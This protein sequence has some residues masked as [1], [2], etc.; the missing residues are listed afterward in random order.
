MI[1]WG[2]LE[3]FPSYC[4][5]VRRDDLRARAKRTV[6]ENCDANGTCVKSKGNR[7]KSDLREAI[8]LIFAFSDFLPKLGTSID[9]AL[10]TVNAKKRP[11]PITIVT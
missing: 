4:P 11:I 8:R 5:T 2:L 6:I 1:V 3:F 9:A 10:Y 7:E